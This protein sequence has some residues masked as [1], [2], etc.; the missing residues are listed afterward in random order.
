MANNNEIKKVFGSNAW[1]YVVMYHCVAIG[2]WDGKNEKLIFHETIAFD[3]NYVTELRVFNNNRELRFL[4]DENDVL[5]CRDSS[6][7]ESSTCKKNIQDTSYLMY[8]TDVEIEEKQGA[9]W[10]ALFEDRGGKV[11]FPKK[12][13]FS[14]SSKEGVLMWLNIRNFLREGENS[15]GGI[16]LEVCDY[17]F[18]GF[19][20]GRNKEGV[21]LDD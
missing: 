1:A 19:S 9:Q 16:K 3:W 13:Y 6:L 2:I 4:R 21:S 18:T 10:T 15:V 5:L 17:V 12:L 11:Y 8:G 20:K 14:Q 7:L